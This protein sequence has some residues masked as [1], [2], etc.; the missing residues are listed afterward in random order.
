[1]KI[2]ARAPVRISFCGGGTDLAAYYEEHGGIVLSA[3]ID[4]YSH[5]ELMSRDDGKI[6]ISSPDYVQRIIGEVG[7]QFLYD[8]NLDLLK[9]AINFIRPKKGFSLT[10]YQDIPSA[11]GLGTSASMAVAALGVLFRF[12]ER[13]INKSYI[14]EDAYFLEGLIGSIT[15]KQDQYA[16]SY[17]GINIFEFPKKSEGDRIKRTKI[18]L[19]A[20]Q[21][22]EFLDH[23]LLINIGGAHI[24]GDLQKSLVV[25]MQHRIPDT[26]IGLDGLKRSTYRMTDYLR[27]Q[28]WQEF[29]EAL[30]QAFILKKMSNQKVSNQHIEV[31]YALARQHGALGGK[32]SGAGGSG[33]L[34]L[35]SFPE[36]KAE[37]LRV[38]EDVGGKNIPF[39]FDEDGLVVEEG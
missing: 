15:G 2:T 8:N 39:D 5:V 16:A 34:L 13:Q 25:K 9:A 11:S 14:A 1:M 31:V 7:Q 29:G 24:S 37:I 20:E 18:N 3:A 10:T 27:Q 21:E 6:E 33:N 36:K 38:L 28:Q 23:L 12:D 17:G 4:K 19:N 30:H 32:I 22:R 26:M 35:F